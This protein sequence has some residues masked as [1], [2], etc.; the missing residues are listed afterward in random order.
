MTIGCNNTQELNSKSDVAEIKNV[1]MAQEQAWNSGSLEDFMKG[2]WKDDRLTF[3]GKSGINYGWTTTLN[4][5]RRGYPNKEAMGILK[6]KVIE[7]NPLSPG[8]YHAIG[9]YTLTRK[10]DQPT[11]F[12]SLLWRRIDGQWYI[13]SDHTSG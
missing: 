3:I 1:L 5:Y 4:N 10:D 11:G 8:L 12:F 9:Q 6:F 2:Y 13:V 7:L